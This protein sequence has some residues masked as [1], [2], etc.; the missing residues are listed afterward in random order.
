MN[1]ANANL[2]ETARKLDLIVAEIVELQAQT[3]TLREQYE[4]TN[5]NQSGLQ[6]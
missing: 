3:H 5:K 1:A 4:N 2:S 6:V